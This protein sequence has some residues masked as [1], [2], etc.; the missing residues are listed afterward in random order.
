M[1]AETAIM[2]T[3]SIRVFCIFWAEFA[4]TD[5]SHVFFLF[6]E[7]HFYT[8]NA[9]NLSVYNQLFL[10]AIS[11]QYMWQKR[12]H[13]QQSMFKVCPKIHYKI[14]MYGFRVKR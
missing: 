9:N 10:G 8:I 14:K 6:F 12:I 1:Y 3:I 5:Q 2:L 7:S 4:G 13:T 11:F